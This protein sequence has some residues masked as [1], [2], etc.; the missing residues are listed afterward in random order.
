MLVPTR[1]HRQAQLP[2]LHNPTFFPLLSLLM[3]MGKQTNRSK[4]NLYVYIQIY[5][6]IYIHTEYTHMYTHVHTCAHTSMHTHTHMCT[7]PHTHV[8][9]Y[10]HTHIC[11]HTCTHTPTAHQLS[12]QSGCSNQ[13]RPSP[14]CQGFS[15]PWLVPS[16]PQ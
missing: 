10:A 16:Y 9:T 3:L 11:T 1:S 12:L 14:A 6:Y 13:L 5:L 2:A 4:Q 8:H 15:S 7:H